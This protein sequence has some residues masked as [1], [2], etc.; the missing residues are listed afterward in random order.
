MAVGV[1][2]RY[3]GISHHLTRS[4]HSNKIPTIDPTEYL[5]IFLISD[6]GLRLREPSGSERIRIA[7]F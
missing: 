4:S 6:L 7:E 3:L 5:F 2:R 1:G